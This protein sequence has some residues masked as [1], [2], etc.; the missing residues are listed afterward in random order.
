MENLEEIAR[1]TRALGACALGRLVRVEVC[2]HEK[3]MG[4]SVGRSVVRLLRFLLKPGFT[5][6]SLAVLDV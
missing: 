4:G 1:N 6:W 2:I 5:K 3:E